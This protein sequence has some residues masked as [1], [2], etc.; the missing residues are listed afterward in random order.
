MGKKDV[1]RQKENV[2]RMKMFGASVIEVSG[3]SQSLKEAINEALRYWVSCAEKTYYVFVTV[4]GPHPFPKMVR[5]FQKVIG[6]EARR[7]IIEAD[8]GLPDYVIDCVGGGS[9]AIGIF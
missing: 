7:Q 4:A 1:A 5:F 8:G 3:G 9:N 2:E 6:K